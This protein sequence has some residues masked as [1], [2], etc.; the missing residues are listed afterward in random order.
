MPIF[1]KTAA[2]QQQIDQ[3]L[4]D[5]ERSVAALS[6]YADYVTVSGLQRIC[7]DF[8]QNIDDFYRDDRKLNIGIIGQVKAGKSTFLNTLLFGGKEILPTARAP[9]TAALT[10]IEY[11]E[12][13]R[14]CVEYYSPEEWQTLESYARTETE[15]NEH[16]VARETIKLVAENGIDPMPYLQMRT[17]EIAFPSLDALMEC[18]NEYVGENGKFTTMFK[19][20]TLYMDKPEL[21]EIS[22][23]DTP[24]MNDAIVSRSERTRDFIGRCDVVFFL[25]R[26]SQFIDENDMKMIQNQIPQKGV[27]RMVLICSRFDEALLDE[28]KKCGSLR[29]TI[30]KLTP[31][32]TEYAQSRFGAAPIFI[33]SLVEAMTG[34]Q[35]S[36]YSRNEAHV[37]KRLN[38]FGDLTQEMMQEIGNLDAVRMLF[39]EV[40]ASKD[41][42]LQQ[43]ASGFIPAVKKEWNAAVRDLVAET[44]RRKL[45][46]ETGDKEILQKQKSVMESQITGIKASLETVLGELRIALEQTKGESLRT[47]RESCRENARLQERTGTEAS[48]H[49]RKYP[50]GF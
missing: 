9:K 19:N 3:F 43:K 36:E 13:N 12:E 11:S 1:E 10:K 33:S 16:I 49:T 34:K 23:V 44:Q 2:S 39:D 38:R 30:E 7:R 24:G 37:F 14:I 48:V 25:S 46:L 40:V 4:A 32:L 29:A 15:D 26:G 47:L 27:A 8:A 5:T 6:E 22:I 41:E 28:L 18:L 50:T 42:T 35:E 20:V 21:A 17:E 45:L 31:K